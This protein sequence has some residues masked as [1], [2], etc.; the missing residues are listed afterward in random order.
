MHLA[1]G[2]LHFPTLA[3]GVGGATVGVAI[4]L[5]KLKEETIPL[6]ALFGSIFF[7]AS[8]IHVNVGI[9]SSH[10]L[11]NGLAGLF[12][13]WAVFPV[14]LVALTLQALLFSFG[15][16]SVLGINLCIVAIPGVLLHYSLRPFLKRKQHNNKHLIKRT[17]NTSPNL[18][19]TITPKRLMVIGILAGALGVLLAAILQGVVLAF[20]GGKDYVN[21]IGL[22][23]LS[24]IP[25]YILDSLIS[26][27]MLVALVKV[28]PDFLKRIYH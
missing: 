7:I 23:F 13:G 8:T 2:I 22:I 27:A 18:T 1:E 17:V 24:H 15:G 28:R 12:L 9:S 21:L 16:F 3:A 11:L 26:S 4:G 20:D 14:F 6:A 19:S 10:L 5:K 25:I